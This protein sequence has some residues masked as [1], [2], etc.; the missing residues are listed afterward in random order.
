MASQPLA[1]GEL[2]A[3][4]ILLAM[5][6]TGSSVREV[7]AGDAGKI[8]PV[9]GSSGSSGGST[10]TSAWLTSEGGPPV[11]GA[12]RSAEGLIKVAES[13]KGVQEGSAEQQKF[14]SAAGISAAQAWCAAFVTW[15]LKRIGVTNLPSDPAA[16]S[17]WEGWSG[18][19]KISSLAKALPGDLI[20][21]NGEHIGIYLGGG[22]MISGNWSNEVAIANVSEESEPIT[23]IIR[24]KGLYSELVKSGG[25]G[26]A[27]TLGFKGKVRV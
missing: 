3:G 13:Q 22:K 5:G 1:F 23:A 26:V 15:A 6:V 25:R 2:L 19:Q 12:S 10:S 18:G 16:V 21:F 11:T 24:V 20:A 27:E 17:S 7:F 8:K 14:A 4:G 9:Q